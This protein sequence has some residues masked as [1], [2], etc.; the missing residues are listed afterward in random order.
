M[1]GKVAS[2]IG[3]ADGRI[4]AVD[5]VALDSGIYAISSTLVIGVP[6]TMQPVAGASPWSA[7]G[8][9]R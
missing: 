6:I 4:G 8:G 2:A 3:A 7:P 1:L 5:L 9:S